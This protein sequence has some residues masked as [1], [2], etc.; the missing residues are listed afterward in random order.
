MP[1]EVIDDLGTLLKAWFQGVFHVV[2][3]PLNHSPSQSRQAF[4]EISTQ[5]DVEKRVNA[6][7]GIAE[8]DGEVIDHIE[9]QRGLLHL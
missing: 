7:A 8:A 3:F 1:I 2:A 6:A 9:S 4:L 5:Q